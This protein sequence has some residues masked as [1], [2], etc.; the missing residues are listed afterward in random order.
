MGIDTIFTL[1]SF[2]PTLAVIVFL[3]IGYKFVSSKVEE[4]KTFLDSFQTVLEAV[5][6]VTA[7]KEALEA[8][9]SVEAVKETVEEIVASAVTPDAGES[10]E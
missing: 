5:K 4:I 2:L 8:T 1:I 6:E 3:F 10:K 7:V 9:N